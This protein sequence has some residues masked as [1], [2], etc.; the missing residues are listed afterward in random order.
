MVET[1]AEEGAPRDA[2]RAGGPDEPVEPAGPD[3]PVE[4]AGPAGSAPVT[5]T[6]RDA[7]LG[8]AATQA[9]FT[10]AAVTVAA[11]SIYD[12][13]QG[14]TVVAGAPAFDPGPFL[15]L[16]TGLAFAGAAAFAWTEMARWRVDIAETEGRRVR[17]R[18]ERRYRRV[19]TLLVVGFG[20]LAGTWLWALDTRTVPVVAVA[21]GL[22]F[23]AASLLRTRRQLDETM[24]HVAVAGLLVMAAHPA[25]LLFWPRVAVGIT[26]AGYAMVGGVLVCVFL[27]VEAR[28]REQ[29]AEASREEGADEGAGG[30]SGG[31]SGS[32]T[33]PTG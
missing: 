27:E 32:R 17:F 29:E 20:L 16:A 26:A 18:R 23:A 31:G 8:Y 25:W 22:P 5:E 1:A 11:A 2:P 10:A 24:E 12:A 13:L 4:P 15:L 6:L 30:G 3:E 28:F 14:D 21:F 7:C 19:Q 9:L 33:A